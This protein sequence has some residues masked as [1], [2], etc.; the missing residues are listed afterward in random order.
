MEGEDGGLTGRREKIETDSSTIDGG[1]VRLMNWRQMKEILTF[2][3]SRFTSK[4]ENGAK[5]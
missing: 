2:S 5:L 1:M 4:T 3:S